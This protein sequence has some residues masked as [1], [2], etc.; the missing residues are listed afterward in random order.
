MRILKTAWLYFL[1]SGIAAAQTGPPPPG[2]YTIV[3]IATNAT[4]SGINNF[5]QVAVSSGPGSAFLWTPTVAN[6]TVGSLIDLGGLPLA[7]TPYN[8]TAGINDR[9]QVLGLTAILPYAEAFLWTPDTPNGTSGT[10]A[11]FAGSAEVNS[12]FSAL[13]INNYG[14]IIG[15]DAAQSRSYLWTPSAPNGSTGTLNLDSRLN[16]VRAINDFGQAV[17]NFS[18]QAMLFTPSTANGSAG[19]YTPVYG[20]PGSLIPG[21]AGINNSGTVLG[22]SY[23]CSD[24]SNCPPFLW[25]PTSPNGTVGTATAIPLLFASGSMFPIALNASGQVVGTATSGS[26]KTAFLYTGGAT[27]DLGV[28]STQLAA[29]VPAGI[30]DLGQIAINAGGAVYLLTPSTPVTPPVPGEVQ[31]TIASDPAGRPFTVSGNGCRPGGYSAPQALGWI[32]GSACTVAFVSPN[33]TDSTTRYVFNGWRDGGSNPRTFTAPSQT[34]TYTAKFTT[35]YY[36]TTLMNLPG[37]GTLTGSGW[38]DSGATATLTATPASGYV[39][40]GWTGVPNPPPGSTIS[41]LTVT[42]P[43]VATAIF[44]QATAGP[45][46]TYAVTFIS[47]GGA[48]SGKTINN[49]GQVVGA[50]GGAPFLWTPVANGTVGSLVSLPLPGAS[51]IASGINDRGQ[52]VGT[53]VNA[54]GHSDSFLWSPTTPNGTTGT[55]TYPGGSNADQINNYGQIIGLGY[56]DSYLWTPST[57]NG[58]TGTVTTGLQFSR[59]M[60]INDFGQV[61]T[62]FTLFTPSVANG[63]TGSS[64]V[65]A[66]GGEQLAINNNGTILGGI[67]GSYGSGNSC[68]DAHGFL[69]A[70]TTPNGTAGSVVA[71]IPLLPGFD[72][73]QPL[74][75]NNL[76]QAVGFLSL[77]SKITPFL[78]SGGI[79]YDL[80]QV[81]SQLTG[82]IAA[83]INDRGQIVVYAEGG[84][85][86]LTPAGSQPPTLSGV[87]SASVRGFNQVM[88]F[89]FNDP[90]GWQDIGVVDILINSVLDGRQAC[91]LAFSQPANLLY[92]V[93]DAGTGVLPGLTLNGSGALVNSQCT[94]NGA[95][96][97]VTRSGATLTLTLNLSLAPGFAGNKVVYV[98]AR[99]IAEFNLGWQP[100]GVWEVPAA[101]V[102]GLAVTR[103][104][105]VQG[106]SGGST[107]T[108]TFTFTDTKGYQDLGV[109][110]ILI[111]NAL[112][113]RQ[114]CYL[115]YSQPSGT[116]YLVND[117]G[118]ALLPGLGLTSGANLSNSQCTVTWPAGTAVT[119]SGSTLTLSLNVTFSPSFSGNKIIYLAARDV[120][121]NNNSG[122]QPVGTWRVP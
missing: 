104:I 97:S 91:Y 73:M 20:P 98:A 94:V 2:N 8:S 45:P 35:Q 83:S 24:L 33:Q 44:V 19:T 111:N 90:A 51:S 62:P 120:T 67:C 86:L 70:P 65:G 106:G 87:T 15:F 23:S 21:V 26:N 76:G 6:G 34:A 7:G 27:Y 116:L 10:I 115:A 80:S 110:N 53:A 12:L 64:T 36:V 56:G 13:A 68:I 31:V 55:V 82:G 49:F 85:Y 113:G 57:P 4:A 52:V 47:T 108:F 14:Q 46:G 16:G 28:M 69:W 112:D 78:Y 48:A 71:E 81:S 107:P 50:Y 117:S 42:Y 59:A 84:L 96:S 122:W 66:T 79:V 105:P 25:T 89:T 74:A 29:G 38:Y 93:N 63:T 41:T 60:G 1:V 37:A 121:G 114:A 22:L 39:L 11:A 40:L 17:I 3:Q 77:G 5:G 102:A 61:I 95:G 88:T 9:G 119:L 72:G 58:A 92:L 54:F 100:M 109:V 18:G 103:A 32:P 30:N 118:T 101:P 99:N 75:L 43:V